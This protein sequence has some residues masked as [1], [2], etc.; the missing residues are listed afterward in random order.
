MSDIRRFTA[1]LLLALWWGGFTFYAGRVVSI[2]HEVLRSTVRQGF[3]TERVTTELN[4][5]AVA[6]L[7][8][9]AWELVARRRA[10]E[11]DRTAWV[12]WAGVL[13]ATA[14][15]FALHAQLAGMLDFARR[16]VADDDHFYARHRLYLWAAAGQWL[17]GLILLHQL[18][19]V[20]R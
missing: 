12:A 1:T 3:I 14:A 6:V 4:R 9:T 20:R 10:G 18:A 16:V 15:L 11:A 8:V 7:A 2:G 5:L 17:A 13:V 19:R